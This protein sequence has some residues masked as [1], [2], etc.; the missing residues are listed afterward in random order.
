MRQHKHS[1]GF[2]LLELSLV[3]AVLS[4][5]LGTGLSYF[6]DKGEETSIESTQT[7]LDVI[8]D[9]ILRYYAINGYLPC[10]APSNASPNSSSFGRSSDACAGSSAPSGTAHAG[11]GDDVVRMGVVPVRA[12]A[13]PDKY[14]YDAWGSQITYAV[15]KK[16]AEDSSSY[17]GFTTTLTN[18]VIN[19]TDKSG[20]QLTPANT[21]SIV[22][23]NLISHGK[24][25]AG[26]YSKTGAQ[27][28]A[29]NS[30]TPLDEENCNGDATFIDDA[31]NDSVTAANYYYDE[32]RW[33]LKDYVG[34]FE[35]TDETPTTT[36]F[37]AS[38]VTVGDG[39]TCGITTSGQIQ[40]WGY[41]AS[42]R[43]GRGYATSYEATADTEA[44][45]KTDWQSLESGDGH[46]CAIDSSGDMYCW[47]SGGY[48]EVADNDT[49]SH[50]QTTPT[51]VYGGISN[52]TQTSNGE[53]RGCAISE[54]KL[55][56]WGLGGTSGFWGDTNLGVP[57]Q[58]GTDTDWI[59]VDAAW[60]LACGIRGTDGQGE[61]YCWGENGYTGRVG[62]GTT[63]DQSTPQL[64]IGGYTDWVQVAGGGNNATCGLRA[65]GEIYCWG[66]K[67]T[68]GMND[69]S[70][71]NQY[72]PR[73]V[74][75]G[76]TD[77]EKVV[78]GS[79]AFCGLRNGRIYCWGENEYGE[80]A[81][82]S[83]TVGTSNYA[84]VPTEIDGGYTDWVDLAA[85]D[86]HV[87]A[88]RVGGTMYCW[89]RNDNYQ[90]GLGHNTSPVNVPS[91]TTTGLS[92]KE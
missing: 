30:S 57:T 10:P 75:G 85:G 38:Y 7:R 81:N 54:G 22:A 27:F 42:G 44:L 14:L 32:S 31:I 29:C 79:K 91:V 55:Y 35:F 63:T 12:L 64:V 50:S 78:G 48:G 71:G 43:L 92:F 58:I 36:S 33:K 25:R 53:S 28:A 23:Y 19:I 83:V 67:H 62:D 60:R 9:A 65:N 52:W 72:T 11:T 76:Y 59:Y 47:G 70:S 77:W 16:L 68:C 56:C 1:L 24:D 40:C 8:E 69:A 84:L 49:S 39:Y 82:S 51:V 88:L 18:G 21:D 89:G 80:I 4:L 45:G 6:A 15:V 41:N 2:T 3:L 46:V 86:E 26:A 74:D 5:M 37:A 20:N 90:L 17:D 13:L 87:C 61:L 73:A 66:D 34:S